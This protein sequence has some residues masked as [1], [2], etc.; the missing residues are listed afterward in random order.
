LTCPSL[1]DIGSVNIQ[2]GSSITLIENHRRMPWVAFEACGPFRTKLVIDESFIFMQ[3]LSR[4]IGKACRFKVIRCRDEPRLPKR[5]TPRHVIRMVGAI[6]RPFGVIWIANDG[7][8]KY[9]VP[10]KERSGHRKKAAFILKSDVFESSEFAGQHIGKS[11]LIDLLGMAFFEGNL[12]ARR[13]RK[14]K[15]PFRSS[16]IHIKN[17]R[18]QSW[19]ASSHV[20]P[21]RASLLSNVSFFFIE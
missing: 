20:Q 5:L 2:P 18:G 14:S 13:S 4:L 21:S 12:F 6:A 16:S 8:V 1:G 15:A 19:I 10:Q 3:K 9:G 17:F 7:S 11:I